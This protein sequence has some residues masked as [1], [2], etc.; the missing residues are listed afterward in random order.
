MVIGI[1]IVQI[2]IKY[3]I[4]RQ[5]GVEMMQNEMVEFV[6]NVPLTNIRNLG[7]M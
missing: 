6:I 3:C 5:S 1:E 7:I 4:I 2:A